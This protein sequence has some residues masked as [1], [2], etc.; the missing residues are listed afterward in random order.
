M[1]ETQYRAVVLKYIIEE[2][3]RRQCHTDTVNHIAWMVKVGDN[4]LKAA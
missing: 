4:L 3:P 1:S 2:T